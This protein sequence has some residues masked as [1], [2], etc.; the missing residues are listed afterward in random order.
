MTVTMASGNREK[1]SCNRYFHIHDFTMGITNYQSK[2]WGGDHENT[3]ARKRRMRMRVVGPHP[4]IWPLQAFGRR[5]P[6]GKREL[7][8][9]SQGPMTSFLGRCKNWNF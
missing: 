3:K 4:L 2:S 6:F 1:W 9:I 7:Q 5:Y 8:P